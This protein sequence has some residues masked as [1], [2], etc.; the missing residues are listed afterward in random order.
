MGYGEFDEEFK[1]LVTFVQEECGLTKRDLRDV[2]FTEIYEDLLEMGLMHTPGTQAV[3]WE[4]AG[5]DD[6]IVQ[7]RKL[8][9]ANVIRDML[10]ILPHGGINSL[11]AD[12]SSE[13]LGLC[14]VQLGN[15]VYTLNLISEDKDDPYAVT[16]EV[17]G[18]NI[19][20]VTLG[21]LVDVFEDVKCLHDDCPSQFET[22]IPESDV[23]G[24]R[25]QTSRIRQEIRRNTVSFPSDPNLN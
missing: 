22:P 24:H 25:S 14:D 21:G 9:F 20:V 13:H 5:T 3:L 19:H 10:D 1:A 12:I 7:A 6:P 2:E 15:R 11:F 18:T 8:G 16:Y 17:F 4:S 23:K